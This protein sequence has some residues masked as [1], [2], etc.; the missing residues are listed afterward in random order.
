MILSIA[1]LAVGAAQ[2]PEPINIDRWITDSDYPPQAIRKNLQGSTRFKLVVDPTGQ[3][4]SCSVI[5]ASGSDVLD[6]KVCELLIKRARFR[7]AK[8]VDG[9]NIYGTM[10]TSVNWRLLSGGFRVKSVDLILVVEKLPKSV[11]MPSKV[12][13]G[14]LVNDK[15]SIESC[16]PQPEDK[17]AKILGAVACQQVQ[18][19]LTFNPMTNLGKVPVR[20]MQNIDVGFNVEIK[21]KD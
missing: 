13:V 2:L 5:L 18:A 17:N 15:G 8:D 12:S 4:E 7:P 1:M 19:L 11:K 3:T 6:N 20:S 16:A 21:R 9:T 10:T 14:V